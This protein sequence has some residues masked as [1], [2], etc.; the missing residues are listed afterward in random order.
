MAKRPRLN[1]GKGPDV[2]AVVPSSI[3]NEASL[4]SARTVEIGNVEVVVVLILAFTDKYMNFTFLS[5]LF[6]VV[7]GQRG[8]RIFILRSVSERASA[9]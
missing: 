8:N 9:E 6:A 3:G 4:S 7:D 2:N 1:N 5:P